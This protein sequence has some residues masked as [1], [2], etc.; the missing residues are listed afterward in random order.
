MEAGREEGNDESCVSFH[1]AD[2][3]DMK[4][5][6][7]RQAKNDNPGW[8]MSYLYSAGCLPP[9]RPKRPQSEVEYKNFDV[10][11][12]GVVIPGGRIARELESIVV[13]TRPQSAYNQPSGK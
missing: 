6:V 2:V 9:L 11:G 8:H 5:D 13:L 10:I 4:A 12:R 1:C 7:N 3:V